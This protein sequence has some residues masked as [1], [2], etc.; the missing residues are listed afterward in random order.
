M[1]GIKHFNG[2]GLLAVFLLQSCME[3]DTDSVWDIEIITTLNTIGYCRSVV[4]VNDTAYVAAG[5]NGIQIW[6]MSG[7]LSTDTDPSLVISMDMYAAGQDF[8][9]ISQV[10]YSET[11]RVIF[12]VESNSLVNIIDKIGS[13]SLDWDGAK[14]SEKTREIRVMDD[15]GGFTIYAADND[16]GLKWNYF[17]LQSWGEWF[18]T[19]GNEIPEGGKPTGIDMYGSLLAQ[20]TDQTGISLY[21]ISSIKSDPV[22]V[23]SADTEGNADKVT[24]T[25]SGLFVASEGGGAYYIPISGTSFG[26]PIQFAEDLY[27]TH[28]SVSGNTA[29]LSLASNGIALYDISNTSAPVSRGIHGIG[30]VY[31]TVHES[32][33]ILACTREGLQILSIKK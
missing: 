9:D 24:F 26:T 8:G 10:E 20:T 14:M 17:E 30:Y 32:N 3:P 28:V 27:V 19:S 6:D 21:Q 7:F 5:Q 16:D 1:T 23:D 11:H 15:S 31:K 18:H 4:V 22:K 13:D 33:Y 12:A 2:L 25:D 29:V